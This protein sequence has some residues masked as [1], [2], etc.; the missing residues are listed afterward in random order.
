VTVGTAAAGVIETFRRWREER[1]RNQAID[2]AR[3]FGWPD[4]EKCGEP[5]GYGG[6]ACEKCSEICDAFVLVG[7]ELGIS[8]E[9]FREAILRLQRVIGPTKPLDTNPS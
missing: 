4:C 6:G 9:E 1:R 5:S 7:R 2:A 8:A 3:W